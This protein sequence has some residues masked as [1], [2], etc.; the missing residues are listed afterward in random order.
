M[1]VKHIST[2]DKI[3]EKM[4]LVERLRQLAKLYNISNNYIHETL[5]EAA[6][7]IVK[8]NSQLDTY[9]KQLQDAAQDALDNWERNQ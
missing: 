8:L 7:E 4:T 2:I 1:I 5:L 3:R 9:D 6:N